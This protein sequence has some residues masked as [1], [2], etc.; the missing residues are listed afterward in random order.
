MTRIRTQNDIILSL[1]DFYRVAQPLLDVKPGTVA[2][3]LVVDGP[4]VQIGKLYEEVASA[5]GKQS[6]RLSLGVDLDKLAS[7]FG[8]IR[9]RGSKASGTAVLT[10]NSLD[11]DIGVNQGDSITAKNGATFNVTTG[12]VVSPVFA[13]SFKATAAKYRSDLDLVGI[14]DQYAVEVLVEASSAG[15]QGNV[16]K[17]SLVSTQIAGITGVT[18]VNAFSGGALAEDDASFRSRILGIFSGA[19]TGTALGYKNAI[20]GDRAVL[21]AIVVVPGDTLMTRDGTQVITNSAGDKIIISEGTGGKVDIYILGTRLLEVVDSFIYRDKSNRNDPTSTLNDSVLGQI[22]DDAGK[23]VTRKRL[24][25]LLSGTLPAQPVNNITRVSGSSSG[26]NFIEKSTDEFGRVSGNYELITDDGEFGGSP[27]GFDRLHFISDRISGF[28]ED[29]T[30]GIFNGQDAL[31][32]TDVLEISGVEQRINITNE[33]SRVKSSDR[34]SIQLSHSPITGVTRVFN[35]TTG[36]RYVVTNQNPDGTGSI[37]TTGRITI[38]GNSLPSTSDTLQVDYIWILNYDPYFDFDNRLSNKNIREVVDSLDWGF[39]N[40]VRREPVTLVSSGSFLTATVAHPI[41]TVASVNVVASEVSSVSLSSNKP[42]VVVSNAVSNVV[43]ITNAST[44]AEIYNT[45]KEDGSFSAYTIFLPTDTSAQYADTV[46]VVYNAQDIFNADGYEGS[47]NS[48]IISIVPS[49]TAVAGTVVEANY[50]ANVNTILPATPLASLPA[51]RSN[52]AFDTLSATGIGSQPTTH[53]FSSPGVVVQNLRQAPSKLSLTIAGSVSAGVITVAGTTMV[54]VADVVYTVGT[55][56]LQQNLTS[57][58]RKSLGLT[59]GA[60]IPSNLKLARLDK[61]ERVSVVS[62]RDDVTDVLVTYDIKGYQIKSNTYVKDESVA[63]SGLTDVEFLLPTTTTN[64]SNV[65]QVGQKLR[66]SFHYILE[67]DSE[68]V[69][70]SRS[71]TLYTNKTFAIIDTIAISSGFT[72]GASGSA[73]LTV[74]NLNQPPVSNR[75]K[76]TY[77][78]LA[79]KENERII[80]TYNQNQLIT[81]STL[82]IENTRPITADVLV[83]S[84]GAVLVDVI[85]NIVVTSEFTNNSNTVKQG[86]QDVLTSTL[87]PRKLAQTVDASDLVNI[88]YTVAGVDR[89]RIIYFNTTGSNGS[90]LSITSDS[91]QF[92]TANSVT[93]NIETR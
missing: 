2:R 93:V 77:D 92:I 83:K 10:F 54:G 56:S 6:L 72:S 26:G 74:N 29:T 68:G 50:I 25:N 80:I 81:D 8:A 73:T 63:N 17:Y 79:P 46:N 71:G 35:L 76:A 36:E 47:F 15:L 32:F 3:D 90:V 62:G 22:A 40:N 84:A 70:F 14:T 31:S 44:G 9:K 48:N 24:D 58:I 53:L 11:A 37:N 5:S 39:S 1:L 57:A 28:Q 34:S 88:A 82:N 66:V 61:L 65:P 49:T 60:S 38:S 41:S 30:K 21:D 52:N 4:A 87:N 18:N 89:A 85:M 43:S 23:T 45:N 64:S 55:E 16:S 75:Y 59:S 91:N 7:N 19:N 33:N 12:L 42:A 67:S 20:L 13:N 86:V 78:Y 51:I 27:W 69:S